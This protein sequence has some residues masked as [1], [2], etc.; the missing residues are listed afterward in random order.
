M[1]RIVSAVAAALLF[2]TMSAGVWAEEG[3]SEGVEVTA[4]VKAWMNQWKS[5]DS[6]GTTRTSNNIILIGPA[7]EVEF[8]INVFVEA[9]Y[10]T[11]LSDYTVSEAGTDIKFSRNDIDLAVGYLFNHN[12][13]AFVGYRSSEI[14]EKDLGTK[15][16]LS[17]S[18]IGVRGSVSVAEA[19]SIYGKATYQFTTLKTDVG[20]EQ[21][22][23][24]IA[25]AGIKY[26]FTKEFAGA[27]GYKYETTKGKDSQVE[28]TFSGATLDVTYTF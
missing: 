21:A 1:K 16:T 22:P 19:L 11:S 20:S 6:A 8:P 12:V 23:G 7:V 10:L 9:S 18:L 5:K 26:A 27:L 15:D 28:D 14:K 25:E 13:G 24:W 3:K 4:G 2:L 17:G